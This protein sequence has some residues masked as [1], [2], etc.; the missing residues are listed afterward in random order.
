MAW[1]C[2]KVLWEYK[3]IWLW[4]VASILKAW[5]YKN[6]SLRELKDKAV[7]LFEVFF[8]MSHFLKKVF[9]EER[10]YHSTI[11]F[12]VFLYLYSFIGMPWILKD[13]NYHQW[14]K[15][16]IYDTCSW[17]I[18]FYDNL[19]DNLIICLRF[20]KAELYSSYFFLCYHKIYY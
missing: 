19:F 8:K 14:S 17:L 9:K 20:Y 3:K 18:W 1:L 11:D 7:S 15:L 12:F 16:L 5:I 13:Y 2:R 10:D 6:I 4:V